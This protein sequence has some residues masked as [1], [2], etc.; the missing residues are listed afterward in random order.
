MFVPLRGFFERGEEV[1][2]CRCAIERFLTSA[3]VDGMAKD[4]V[5]KELEALAVRAVFRFARR[6][7]G[8]DRISLELAT[9]LSALKVGSKYVMLWLCSSSEGRRYHTPSQS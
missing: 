5:S 3:D 7:P 1:D 4:A 9:P 2:I 6:E 8:T